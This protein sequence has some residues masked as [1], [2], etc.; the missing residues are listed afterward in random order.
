ML[1]GRFSQRRIFMDYAAGTEPNPSSIHADGVTLRREFENARKKLAKALATQANE[2]IFTS[3]GTEANNLAILGTFRTAKKK[4]N[5]PHIITS[6][7]E[8]ASVLEA[9]KQAE[10]EGAEVSYLPVREDGIVDISKLES[11]IKAETVLVSLMHANNETGTLQPVRE[12]GIIVKKLKV[13]VPAGRQESR[14]EYPYFHTDASQTAGHRSIEPHAFFADLLTISGHKVYG[15]KGTGLLFVKNGTDIEPLFFGGGQERGLRPGTENVE[16]Q[17]KFAEAF[18]EVQKNR[19]EESKRLEEV[20]HFFLKELSTQGGL[21]YNGSKGHQL[22]NI[23]N[24]SFMSIESDRMVLELDAKGIAVSA[25]SACHARLPAPGRSNGGQ[26]GNSAF[27]QVIA[28]MKGEGVAKHAIRFSL[29]RNTDKKNVNIVVS[30][31]SAILAA[32]GRTQ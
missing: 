2:L 15:P 16:G 7:I 20:R 26:A 10:R 3:G 32:N 1:F 25:G 30:E 21:V 29:G 8:H 5:K 24:V 19:Q 27:S 6:N 23:V 12:V 18:L 11:L 31:I 22:P 28:N 17:I 4:I 14:K 9:V 13:A